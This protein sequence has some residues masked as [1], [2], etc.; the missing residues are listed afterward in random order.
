LNGYKETNFIRERRKSNLGLS[1]SM[2]QASKSQVAQL[3][4]NEMR[5]IYIKMK[6]N[7]RNR[8]RKMYL[9]MRLLYRNK[10]S[11]NWTGRRKKEVE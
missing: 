6:R 7:E 2:I 11:H 5:R 3:W 9:Q 4:K 8:K 1:E 10:R